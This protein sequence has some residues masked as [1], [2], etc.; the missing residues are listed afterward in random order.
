MQRG[1]TRLLH[2]VGRGRR[3]RGICECVEGD[4][5]GERAGPS[6]IG[7]GQ[8]ECVGREPTEGLADERRLLSSVD[9]AEPIALRGKGRWAGPLEYVR[10]DSL[11]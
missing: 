2:E 8:P 9:R 10:L 6:L 1:R 4:R 11:L 5:A 7:C 3:P